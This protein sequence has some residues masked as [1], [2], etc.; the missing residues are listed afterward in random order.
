MALTYTPK[1]RKSW[2]LDT[3]EL[4]H[5][6][7]V[8]LAPDKEHIVPGSLHQGIRPITGQWLELGTIRRKL[9]E[10][11]FVQQTRFNTLV[12]G[13]L[14][15]N[16]LP[17]GPSW[18]DIQTYLSFYVIEFDDVPYTVIENYEDAS[19]ATGEEF[20]G[21]IVNPA[22]DLIYPGRNPATPIKLQAYYYRDGY[23]QLG[24][25]VSLLV[26][27]STAENSTDIGYFL[28]GTSTYVNQFFST[29][30]A[31]AELIVK[32]DAEYGYFSFVLGVFDENGEVTD[33]IFLDDI[34][35]HFLPG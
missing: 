27:F 34:F 28:T 25:D 29:D 33:Y 31:D 7:F 21:D 15:Q 22:L 24:D 9:A 5:R 11:Y 32:A 8:Q 30:T 12:P 10:R 2:M 35:N 1:Q 13:L 16:D 3:K 4:R 17:P 20:L 23:P 19:L 18:K 6:Y 26:P 14:V